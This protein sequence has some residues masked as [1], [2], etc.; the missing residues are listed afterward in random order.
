MV[1]E[2]ELIDFYDDDCLLMDDFTLRRFAKRFPMLRKLDMALC[3]NITDKSLQS[4][5]ENCSQLRCLHI[6]DCRLITEKGIR[7]IANGCGFLEDLHFEQQ[8]F[9][10]NDCC[11]AIGKHSQYMKS[12]VLIDTG[13]TDSGIEAITLN[14]INLRKLSIRDTFFQSKNIE[15]YCLSSIAKKC[16]HLEK[17]HVFSAKMDDKSLITLFKNSPQLRELHLED[18]EQVT[19]VAIQELAKNC[20]K[21]REL[22][23]RRCPNYRDSHLD[24]MAA[25]L[26]DLR[27]LDILYCDMITERGKE[28]FD[29]KLPNCFLNV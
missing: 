8:P 4:I 7:F 14:A 18:C 23:L 6:K 26:T 25:N 20:R 1:S 19:D 24:L 2:L 27:R 15:G 28:K 11:Q 12:L 21:L 17:L 16:N 22:Y 13:I 29:E 10:N 9:I 3:Y 5:A